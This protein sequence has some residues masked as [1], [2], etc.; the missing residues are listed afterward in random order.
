MLTVILFL[1]CALRLKCN[2][3]K[4]TGRRAG[5]QFGWKNKYKC[6]K[7]TK[8]IETGLWISSVLF[9]ALAGCE[10]GNFNT[11]RRR[12]IFSA[13]YDERREN[14]AWK[15][16]RKEIHIKRETKACGRPYPCLYVA[17]GNGN[18]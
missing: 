8:R 13:Q 3:I 6:T 10:G 17:T 4:T 9:I 11:R 12:T 5:Y 18:K 16:S 7:R 15:S 2:G 1:F 14:I